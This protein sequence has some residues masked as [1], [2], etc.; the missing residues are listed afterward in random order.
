MFGR[1]GRGIPGY[2][3]AGRLTGI[4]MDWCLSSQVFTHMSTS[5]VGKVALSIS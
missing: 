3:V 5:F 4:S 1:F 2:F